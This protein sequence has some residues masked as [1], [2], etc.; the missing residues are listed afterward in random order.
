MTSCNPQHYFS[1]GLCRAEMSAV[2]IPP[3]YR[4]LPWVVWG[5]TRPEC[6]W[7]FRARSCNGVCEGI[8]PGEGDVGRKS[9]SSKSTS[10]GVQTCHMH[11]HLYL[12][13]S[14]TADSKTGPAG[15]KPCLKWRRQGSHMAATARAAFKAFEACSW[16]SF[17]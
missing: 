15:H 13:F 3:N 1:T 17:G 16:Q 10:T 9:Q 2:M 14:L 8:V 12:I 7:L 11:P 6:P 4:S 5:T